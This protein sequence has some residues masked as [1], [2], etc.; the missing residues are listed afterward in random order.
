M[1]HVKKLH[2]KY[3]TEFKNKQQQTNKQKNHLR[4]LLCKIPNYYKINT[5]ITNIVRNFNEVKKSI[6]VLNFS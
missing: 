2:T 4:S 6:S 3:V 5:L 1:K